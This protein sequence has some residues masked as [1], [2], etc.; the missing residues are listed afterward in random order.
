MS[1]SDGEA[2]Q[3][4]GSAPP[5]PAGVAVPAT[6]H[7]VWKAARSGGSASSA[8]SSSGRGKGP[9]K[10]GA[11]A[12]A[13]KKR[14]EPP[15]PPPPPGKYGPIS[16]NALELRL[17]QEGDG[18]SSCGGDE[19]T[20]IVKKPKT[21]APAKAPARSGLEYDDSEEDDDEAALARVAFGGGG[22]PDDSS[23]ASDNESATSSVQREA[24]RKAMPVGGSACIGCVMPGRVGV[25][26]DFVRQN[27]PNCTETS[28]YKMAALKY[29]TAVEE[30]A[31][32]EGVVCPS[33]DW[34]SIRDRARGHQT[35]A[36]CH[37]NHTSRRVPQTTSCTRSIRA[38]SA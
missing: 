26:D 13:K 23:V 29:K 28:L 35:H 9:A 11:K 14:D 18:A 22:A 12:P 38:H 25:I 19:D 27:A 32:A 20:R 6:S 8:A 15:P 2:P 21:K 7:P 24:A 10:K 36:Q 16:L 17:R 5:P 37:A 30:P 4:V 33:W 1:D 34:R 31:R 3:S